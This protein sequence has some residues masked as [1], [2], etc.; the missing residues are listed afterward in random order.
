[1]AAGAFRPQYD[2]AARRLQDL[3][4]TCCYVAMHVLAADCKTVLAFTWLRHDQAAN[5]FAYTFSTLPREQMASVAVQC[6]FEYVEHTCMSHSWWNGLR[7][8]MR[9]ALLERV[10]RANALAYRHSPRCLS[11]RIRSGFRCA[12]L[13]VHHCLPSRLLHFSPL[14]T[15]QERVALL[16]LSKK[17]SAENR[18]MVGLLIESFTSAG[19]WADALELSKAA[20]DGIEDT[21]RNTQVRLHSALRMIACDFEAAVSQNDAARIEKLGKDFRAAL[22]AIEEDYE[23]NKVRR[24]PLR[25]LPGAR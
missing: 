8:P 7:R 11:Y 17:M 23:A 18:E 5:R 14:S 25:G 24:D 13:P 15:T 4:D 10:R 19:L 1:M 3:R 2:F 22:T 16:S 12:R 20:Y 21:I 6:A 9:A